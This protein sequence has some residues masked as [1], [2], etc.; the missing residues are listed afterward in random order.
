MNEESILIF[1][2]GAILY[3]SII[4]ACIRTK[5]SFIHLISL[6]IIRITL[7]LIY[8]QKSYEFDFVVWLL[9]SSISLILGFI[10]TTMWS[11]NNTPALLTSKPASPNAIQFALFIGVAFIFYHYAV[12]GL[13][14]LS[15]NIDMVRFQQRE[16]GLFGIPSRFAVYFPS[17]I[18]ITSVILYQSKNINKKAFYFWIVVSLFFFIAQGN[19]SSL[20]SFVFILLCTKRFWHF[21][22][23]NRKVLAGFILTG[24][25]FLYFTFSK[26]STLADTDFFDYMIQRLT[27]ISLDPIYAVY[28]A[29]GFHVDAIASSIIINDLIYPIAQ[30]FGSDGSTFNTQLSRHIYGFNSNQF[31]VP[32]TPSI[33]AYYKYE[34]GTFASVIACLITGIIIGKI[35]LKSNRC[36]NAGNLSILLFCEYQIYTGLASGNLF[37]MILNVGVI[38]GAYKVAI[39]MYRRMPTKGKRT[40]PSPSFWP[41]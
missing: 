29:E 32:V 36:H 7:P 35:F 38:I 15:D 28:R 20:L 6:F 27:Y 2:L 40:L 10:V 12:V 39:S 16:S 3:G 30:V 4:F 9:L 24:V 41:N 26:Y 23:I 11:K 18:L 22:V 17:L 13:P 14:I 5:I 33:L 8:L 21:P 25:G 34:F 31:S 19:K 37:Y 1:I